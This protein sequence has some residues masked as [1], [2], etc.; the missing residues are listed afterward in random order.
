[1]IS[2]NALRVV[3]PLILPLGFGV[4]V[5]EVLHPYQYYLPN[6][7]RVFR[8]NCITPHTQFHIPVSI[9]IPDIGF[10]FP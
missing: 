8:V 5:L 6:V 9:A 7:Y 10:L 4:G 3:I 2:I 1:M